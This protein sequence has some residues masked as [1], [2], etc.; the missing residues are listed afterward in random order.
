MSV[1]DRYLLSNAAN[2][3][4]WAVSP[5][6]VYMFMADGSGALSAN[7][8]MWGPMTFFIGNWFNTWMAKPERK[9]ISAGW[10]SLHQPIPV[11]TNCYKCRGVVLKKKWVDAR[12]S[13]G[14]KRTYNVNKGSFHTKKWVDAVLLRP[15]PSTPLSKS[16]VNRGALLCVIVQWLKSW[17]REVRKR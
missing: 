16:L 3:T 10:F 4:D 12:L 8:F 7:Y 15:R 13:Q 11:V 9:T 14:R 2:G 1:C 17:S 6:V 5:W